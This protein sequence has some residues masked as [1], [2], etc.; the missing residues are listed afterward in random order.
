MRVLWCSAGRRVADGDFLVLE[1]R[2][3]SRRGSEKT[4]V[5]QKHN[6]TLTYVAS[7]TYATAFCAWDS[8][9]FLVEHFLR[10]NYAVHIILTVLL[11]RKKRGYVTGSVHPFV[12]LF[13]RLVC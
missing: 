11:L 10:S 7:L 6:A 13:V 3:R 12:C 4:L 9:N 8:V 5:V 1:S 2:P